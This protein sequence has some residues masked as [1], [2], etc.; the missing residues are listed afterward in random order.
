MR[1]MKYLA[2]ALLM[3]ASVANATEPYKQNARRMDSLALPLVFCGQGANATTNYFGPGAA[4]S[5]DLTPGGAAC[6][7]LDN[8]TLATIDDAPYGLLGAYTVTGMICQMTETGSTND[9]VTFTLM[10]DT[11]AVTGFACTTAALNGAGSSGCTAYA[12]P[13]AV[14]AASAM[15][16]RQVRSESGGA[17]DL[18]ATDAICYVFATF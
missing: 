11:A 6:D 7:A 12:T 9:T 16:V 14:G 17:D 18:S 13:V 1:N 5:T 2:L 10:D 8:T 3:I 4:W 15:A